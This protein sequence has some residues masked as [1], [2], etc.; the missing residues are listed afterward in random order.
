MQSGENHPSQEA[1]SRGGFRFLHDALE[2]FLNGVIAQV[3]AV[4]DFLV[5]EAEHE[6]DDHHLLTLGEVITLLNVSIRIFK[7]LMELLH[8]DE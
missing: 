2:V 7:F 4:G 8:N 6:I 3:K 1:G 5:G